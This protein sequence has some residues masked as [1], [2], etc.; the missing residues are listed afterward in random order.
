LC[1]E[2]KDQLVRMGP[3]EPLEQ[4]GQ[5]DRLAHKVRKV[6]KARLELTGL[7]VLMALAQ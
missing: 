2:R 6:Y 3:L 4:R 7:T 1:K 5:Q